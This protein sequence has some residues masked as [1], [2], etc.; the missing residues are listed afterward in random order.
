MI[1]KEKTYHHQRAVVPAMSTATTMTDDDTLASAYATPMSS[2]ISLYPALDENRVV[3]LYL[4]SSSTDRS[5]ST[6]STTHIIFNILPNNLSSKFTQ[7]SLFQVNVKFISN[8]TGCS[9][10]SS[11]STFSFSVFSGC[12]FHS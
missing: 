11:T 1:L 5:G 12:A 9:S 8:N 6:T 7:Q 2:I 10:I 3:D 4:A